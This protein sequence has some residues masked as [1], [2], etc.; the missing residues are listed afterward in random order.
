MMSTKTGEQ[1]VVHFQVPEK[2]DQMG[3]VAKDE[4]F[5]QVEV[6]HLRRNLRISRYLYWLCATRAGQ[7]GRGK[8]TSFRSS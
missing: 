7:Y 1:K 3:S 8:R 4:E 2:L 6:N 5:L